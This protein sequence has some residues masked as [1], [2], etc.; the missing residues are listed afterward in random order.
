MFRNKRLVAIGGGILLIGAILGLGL[1]VGSTPSTAA[2]PNTCATKVYYTAYDASPGSNQFGPAQWYS[3][4]KHGKARFLQKICIDPLFTATEVGFVRQSL[5]LDTTP[6]EVT[7]ALYSQNHSLWL[8]DV[9]WLKSQI[10]SYSTMY[11]PNDYETLGQV[12]GANRSVQPKLFKANPGHAV[13]WTLVLHLKNGGT[14]SNRI[15]CDLQPVASTFANVPPVVVT[16]PATTSVKPS[17]TGH[18][19]PTCAELGTCSTPKPSCH[20]LS[21]A[22]AQIP[23]G[24]GPGTPGASNAPAPQPIAPTP[25]EGVQAPHPTGTGSNTGVDSG[26]FGSGTSCNV[27]SSTCL[28]GGAS[29]GSGSTDTTSLGNSKNGTT[30]TTSTGTGTLPSSP[31]Q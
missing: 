1:T 25:S 27:Q 21:K 23:V 4:V 14:R 26:S 20:C 12:I 17:S 2:T 11:N 7:A 29:T 5:N 24:N 8:K 13:G 31:F 16:P 10:T 22:A 9:N 28:G 3:D 15:L 18:H 30:G 6:V 19:T